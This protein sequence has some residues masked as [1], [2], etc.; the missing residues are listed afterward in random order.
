MGC[1]G[2]GGDGGEKTSAQR[3]RKRYV[4]GEVSGEG[5]FIRFSPEELDWVLA[6]FKNAPRPEGGLNESIYNKVKAGGLT[7]VGSY[8][9]A[10]AMWDW[11][12]NAIDGSLDIAEMFGTMGVPNAPTTEIHDL[13]NRLHELATRLDTAGM[14][15]RNRSDAP[16][17]EDEDADG[18]TEQEEGGDDQAADSRE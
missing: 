15:R 2:C 11:L 12:V 7:D 5:A 18:E 16:Q 8:A 10:G 3:K 1:S 4:P 6:A 13:A 9:E 14:T 17:V